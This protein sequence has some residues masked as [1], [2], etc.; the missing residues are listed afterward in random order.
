[1]Y[2]FIVPAKIKPTLNFG[3]FQIQYGAVT[4]SSACKLVNGTNQ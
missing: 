4:L 2:K 1:M 3:R